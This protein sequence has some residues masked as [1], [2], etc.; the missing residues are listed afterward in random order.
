[1][2]SESQDNSMDEP[3]AS[4]E[5]T[6][7]DHTMPDYVDSD[8]EF[9]A[10]EGSLVKAAGLP[11]GDDGIGGDDGRTEE[12]SSPYESEIPDYSD[13]G[14]DESDEPAE[15]DKASLE[16]E[17]SPSRLERFGAL[18]VANKVRIMVSCCVAIIVAAALFVGIP[19]FHF[20][21]GE[22]ALADG[23]YERAVEEYELASWFGPTQERI[24]G[25]ARERMA[26]KD[27]ETAAFLFGRSRRLGAKERKAY[28]EGM[29]AYGEGNLQDAADLFAEAGEVEAAPEMLRRTSYEYGIELMA[30]GRYESAI[31][32][33]VTADVYP[34]ASEAL[35][36]A[37]YNRG[38]Q[39]MDALNYSDARD[40]FAAAGS[41]GDAEAWVKTCDQIPD[42]LSAEE[43]YE[44]GNLSAAQQAFASLPRELTW[45]G[46][47]VGQR[48]DTLAAHQAFVDMCGSYRISSGQCEVRQTHNST[49][50]WNNWTADLGSGG[51]TADIRCTI[52][53]DGSV[54]VTGSADYYRYTTFSVISE[55]VEGTND[56]ASFSLTLSSPPADTPVKDYT[57]ITWSNGTLSLHYGQTDNS[58]DVY[59]TYFYRVDVSYSKVSSY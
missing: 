33:F 53:G 49:G 37:N 52:N 5:P 28:C 35:V 34:G 29:V 43:D 51:Y 50:I 21:Q 15:P 38:R 45:D 27:Y 59:F 36:E 7:D 57:T 47:N 10:E 32:R 13:C 58:Q 44:D 18:V 48:Q 6:A 56:T 19:A 8:G 41:Y 22:Q 1:M 20:H 2:S 31:T 9:I 39:L 16:K 55:G 3:T 23:D 11:V 4:A 17:P 26:E 24:H 12:D 54:H 14:Q 40:H 25:A 46:V 30:E 42:L